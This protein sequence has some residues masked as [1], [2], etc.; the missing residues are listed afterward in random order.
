MVICSLMTLAIN[1]VSPHP[2]SLVKSIHVRH[3]YSTVRVGPTNVEKSFKYNCLPRTNGSPRI[4]H[5]SV[6]IGMHCFFAYY[7]ISTKG[8]MISKTSN[9]GRCSMRAWRSWSRTCGCG[10]GWAASSHLK[11]W[12]PQAATTSLDCSVQPNGT[13]RMDYICSL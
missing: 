10:C 9:S 2:G 13:P 4:L 8:S 6:K 12:W 7:S 1:S 11:C 5:S 3:R